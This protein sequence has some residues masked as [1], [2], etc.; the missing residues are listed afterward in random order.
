M[1]V[2]ERGREAGRERGTARR[3]SPPSLSSLV[4]GGHRG[5]EEGSVNSRGDSEMDVSMVA[6]PESSSESSG[7]CSSV[8]EHRGGAGEQSRE[9]AG[10]IGT[11]WRT[12]G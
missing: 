9:W 6:V 7:G 10:F 4:H 3:K 11:R 12:N 8:E 1:E 5:R 2:E